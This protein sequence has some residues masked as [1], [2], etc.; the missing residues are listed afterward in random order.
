VN[1]TD[2]NEVTL[3]INNLALRVSQKF[4][5]R[6]RFNLDSLRSKQCSQK[7]TFWNSWAGCKRHI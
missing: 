7:Q 3:H 4:L 2:Q 6:D 5:L 1:P